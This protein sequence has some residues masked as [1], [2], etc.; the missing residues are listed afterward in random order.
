[1]LRMCKS[2]MIPPLSLARMLT[3]FRSTAPVSS[4]ITYRGTDY[5]RIN[6]TSRLI[7][8]VTSSSDLLNYYIALGDDV[9]SAMTGGSSSSSNSSKKF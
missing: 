6:L 8:E 4:K 2:F 1:M 9:I 7:Y 5:L 3:I